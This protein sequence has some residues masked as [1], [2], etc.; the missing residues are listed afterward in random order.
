MSVFQIPDY[1]G[2]S[3]VATKEP[4][5]SVEAASVNDSY[6][7]LAAGSGDNQQSSRYR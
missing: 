2:L 1:A 6:A 7:P 4:T 3:P 5:P